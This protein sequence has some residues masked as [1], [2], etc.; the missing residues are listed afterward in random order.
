MILKHIKNNLVNIVVIEKIVEIAMN[1]Q[2]FFSTTFHDFSQAFH[3][4]FCLSEILS[5]EAYQ[6]KFK[7]KFFEQFE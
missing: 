4:L 2:L 1:Y 3:N 5:Q 6:I 7:T